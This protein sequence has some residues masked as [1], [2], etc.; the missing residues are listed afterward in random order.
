MKRQ[1]SKKPDTDVISWTLGESKRIEG[2]E[3]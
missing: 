1:D 3:Y 2:G